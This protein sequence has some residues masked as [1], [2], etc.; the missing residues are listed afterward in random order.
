MASAGK[1]N[2]SNGMIP[3]ATPRRPSDPKRNRSNEVLAIRHPPPLNKMGG[4]DDIDGKK[5]ESYGNG[6]IVFKAELSNI[7][8][9]FQAVEMQLS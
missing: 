2:V 1:R 5:S 3:K 6:S 7:T 4:A 8:Q 9:M